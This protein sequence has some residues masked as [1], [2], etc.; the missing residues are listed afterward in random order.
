MDS[1]S[2]RAQVC[3]SER[4]LGHQSAYVRAYVRERHHHHHQQRGA[5]EAASTSVAVKASGSVNTNWAH[6]ACRE[7]TP[8]AA[9]SCENCRTF[10]TG[11]CFCRISHTS[12]SHTHACK[13]AHRRRIAGHG[14]AIPVSMQH[15]AYE[16]VRIQMRIS[17]ITHTYIIQIY[18]RVV[19]GTVLF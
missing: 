8:A 4:T 11:K 1:A 18:E 16:A 7:T 19:C 12:S 10:A 14:N 5:V 9:G 17:S 13:R 6:F 15:T 3:A 2:V